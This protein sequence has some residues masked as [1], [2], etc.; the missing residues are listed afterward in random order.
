MMCGMAPCR[1]GGFRE[2]EGRFNPTGAGLKGLVGETEGLVFRVSG[3][4]VARSIAVCT[5]TPQAF[6]QIL[7]A[8]GFGRLRFARVVGRLTR[9]ASLRALSASLRAPQEGVTHTPPCL[10]TH[11]SHARPFE[12]ILGP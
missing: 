1:G 2:A 11:V 4:E 8:E 9:F 3:N 12:G 7:A 5:R 10:W 6:I